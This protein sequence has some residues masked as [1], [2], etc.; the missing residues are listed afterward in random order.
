MEYV[1]GTAKE[2]FEEGLQRVSE[3]VSDNLVKWVDSRM[4][5]NSWDYAGF[6]EVLGNATKDFLASVP[7][8]A[9]LGFLPFAGATTMSVVGNQYAKG[10]ERKAKAAEGAA[11]KK[12]P[13]EPTYPK[14]DIETAIEQEVGLDD[15]GMA[16]LA[17]RVALATGGKLADGRVVYATTEDL[18]TAAKLI[19]PIG[20]DGTRTLFRDE[21]GAVVSLQLGVQQE[22]ME[23][24]EPDMSYYEDPEAPHPLA[25]MTKERA[26][27]VQE[28]QM[29]KD[30]IGDVVTH[31]E[32]RI[33]DADL[34]AS[35]DAVKLFAETLGMP[36]DEL[37]GK[38]VVFR[39][40]N[41]IKTA[42]GRSARGAV[43]NISIDGKKQYVIHLSKDADVT[44]IVH[45][46]AHVFR[47]MASAEQLRDFRSYYGKGMEAAFI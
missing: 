46:M 14:I 42:K 25:R 32:G 19:N 4:N 12:P 45:E 35:V 16:S 2:S 39:L 6:R 10:L 5:G 3:D 38:G 18:A 36:T 37:V 34:E 13:T 41:K 27:E 11:S 26:L 33:S 21:N 8:M 22:G 28:R 29:I 20:T 17:N 7:T 24:T 1:K 9:T 30:A 23:V 15:E 43:E 44:T 47:G 40:E 31:T